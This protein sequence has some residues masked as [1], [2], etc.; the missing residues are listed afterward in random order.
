MVN[1][2]TAS[3]L[4]DMQRVARTGIVRLTGPR[5]REMS[6]LARVANSLKLYFRGYTR[7][8]RSDY[9][10]LEITQQAGGIVDAADKLQLAALKVRD[11]SAG[12]RGLEAVAE[13]RKRLISA[14]KRVNN[15]GLKAR[16]AGGE[17]VFLRETIMQAKARK[18]M[19]EVKYRAEVVLDTIN[20]IEDA[21]RQGNSQAAFEATSSCLS[22]QRSLLKLEDQGQ[23]WPEAVRATN[24][25]WRRTTNIEAMLEEKHFGQVL[26]SCKELR[27]LIKTRLIAPAA[28]ANPTKARKAAKML[29]KATLIV[30]NLHD[31]IREAGKAGPDY[32]LIVTR[33]Q[34]AAENTRIMAQKLNANRRNG[35][36]VFSL[37]RAVAMMQSVIEDAQEEYPLNPYRLQQALAIV[38]PILKREVSLPTAGTTAEQRRPLKAR[39]TKITA[40]PRTPLGPK[41]FNMN[42]HKDAVIDRVRVGSGLLTALDVIQQGA[43]YRLTPADDS[44]AWA[45][46][47]LVEKSAYIV[48]EITSLMGMADP[49]SY[50]HRLLKQCLENAKTISRLTRKAAGWSGYEQGTLQD[51]ARL[52]A[53][54]Q[55]D[56]TK[57]IGVPGSYR[58]ARKAAGE[59][60]DNP[61]LRPL[62][63]RAKRALWAAEELYRKGDYK[64][65][66]SALEAAYRNFRKVQQ[67]FRALRLREDAA[68]LT[69]V[70]RMI[71]KLYEEIGGAASNEMIMQ[72]GPEQPKWMSDQIYAILARMPPGDDL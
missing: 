62:V 51:A 45:L 31:A 40:P 67:E 2:I 35:P 20:Q 69:P 18:A 6:V 23:L 10:P 3:W 28:E 47:G 4:D 16:K 21:A 11:G 8:S 48:R 36:G 1:A 19:P 53:S 34:W 64:R 5:A 57:D 72:R 63:D 22:A 33:L 15:G 24:Q 71:G 66:W 49:G 58:K 54:I 27:E 25:M 39:S 13:E 38:E 55:A 46:K 37:Y 12:T 70:V 52:A 26:R 60:Q 14:L 43:Y 50:K 56:L 9:L 44:V 68:A 41:V 32:D 30:N 42:T 61:Q 65:G 7:S 59:W 17:D 29:P